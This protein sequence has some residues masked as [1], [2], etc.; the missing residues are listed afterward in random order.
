M[1]VF[2]WI[3]V[4]RI[5][6]LFGIGI[7]FGSLLLICLIRLWIDINFDMCFML[8]F[9]LFVVIRFFIFVL[10]VL[11]K[12][13]NVFFRWFLFRCCRLIIKLGVK[14]RIVNCICLF[15]FLFWFV[16]VLLVR[17]VFIDLRIWGGIWVLVIFL[18]I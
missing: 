17:V 7:F 2:F 9:F 6:D 15:I 4:K 13:L 3:K 18:Y 11:K 1:W 14:F 12:V 8:C 10:S 16:E 5:V